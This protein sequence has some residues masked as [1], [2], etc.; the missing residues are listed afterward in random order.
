LGSWRCDP[1][2]FIMSLRAKVEV[3]V[4]VAEIIRWIVIGCYLLT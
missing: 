3:R 2:G 4:D 1:E